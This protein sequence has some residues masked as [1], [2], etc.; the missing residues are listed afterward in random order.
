MATENKGIDEEERPHQSD[1]EVVESVPTG[2]VRFTVTTNKSKMDADGLFRKNTCLMN[3]SLERGDHKRSS[4]DNEEARRQFVLKNKI[5]AVMKSVTPVKSTIIANGVEEKKS[6]SSAVL[7]AEASFLSQKAAML[8]EENTKI[9]LQ[10]QRFDSEARV[11]DS[12]QSSKL[13]LILLEEF[14]SSKKNDPVDAH[15]QRKV[16]LESSRSLLGD[17]VTDK[18]LKQLEEECLKQLNYDVI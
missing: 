9:Q 10:N 6:K 2:L 14:K 16:K 5:N 4:Q 11:E 1:G 3:E 7:T 18:K 13:V 17:F 12:K 15:L 8:T